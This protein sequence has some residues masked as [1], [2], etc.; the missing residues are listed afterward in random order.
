MKKSSGGEKAV[1][2]KESHSWRKEADKYL[3]EC[4]EIEERVNDGS[5]EIQWMN[6]YMPSNSPKSTENVIII[7]TNSSCY[8]SNV[9]DIAGVYIG[10]GN[11]AENGR[12]IAKYIILDDT[13]KQAMNYK[14]EPL[15]KYRY[16]FYKADLD[17]SYLCHIYQPSERSDMDFDFKN[18]EIYITI[19]NDKMNGSGMS[20]QQDWRR[21]MKKGYWMAGDRIEGTGELNEIYYEYAD[22]SDSFASET[23]FIGKLAL[24]DGRKVLVTEPYSSRKEVYV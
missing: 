18:I 14:S 2:E 22:Y 19:D 9:K 1:N 6:A 15:V 21:L 24:I 11:I 10:R 17:K 16:G 5:M 8:V 20:K 12:D 4:I 7:D 3:R 13:A 23:D